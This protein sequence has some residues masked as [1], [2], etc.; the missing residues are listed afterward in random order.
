MSALAPAI[1]TGAAGAIVL[2]SIVLYVMQFLPRR[3]E[4]QVNS[5][6]IKISD[7]SAVTSEAEDDLW[8]ERVRAISDHPILPPLDIEAADVELEYSL[9]QVSTMSNSLAGGRDEVVELSEDHRITQDLD[10]STLVHQNEASGPIDVDN[11]GWTLF[12]SDDEEELFGESCLYDEENAVREYI[13]GS[14]EIYGMFHEEE[15]IDKEAGCKTLARPDFFEPYPRLVKDSQEG[16]EAEESR[17]DSDQADSAR[18]EA[19]DSPIGFLRTVCFSPTVTGSA[20]DVGLSFRLTSGYP[21]VTEVVKSS[22][23]FGRVVEGDFI[24]EVDGIAT[25][26]CSKKRIVEFIDTCTT[27]QGPKDRMVQLTIISAYPDDDATEESSTA[28]D[29]LD[30]GFTESAVEV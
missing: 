21:M 14:E 11:V 3:N 18:E 29:S 28:S 6:D 27:S 16:R 1:I 19:D 15:T 8:I 9:S 13:T 25:R 2:S 5:P 22:I 17:Q 24:L 26:D 30:L 4:L 7:T 10:I 12:D 20:C 23:L